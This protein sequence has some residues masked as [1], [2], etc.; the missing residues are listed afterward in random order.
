MKANELRIGNYV[1]LKHDEYEYESFKFDFDMGWNMEFIH[2]ILLTEEWLLKFG[3]DLINNEYHQSRNHELKLYW[4]VNKNKM[5]PEFNE[6]RFVTGYDFKYVHQLQ[7]LYFILTGEE[8]TI[9]N[10]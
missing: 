10:K 8:L 1:D 3:F 5:I 2:P 7:N 4:T 6:K 9:K